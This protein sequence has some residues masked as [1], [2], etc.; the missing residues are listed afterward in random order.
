VDKGFRIQVGWRHCLPQGEGIGK[1]LPHFLSSPLI[2]DYKTYSLLDTSPL[3]RL[4]KS[5]PSLEGRG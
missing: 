3:R 4:Q 2:G 5:F 1:S